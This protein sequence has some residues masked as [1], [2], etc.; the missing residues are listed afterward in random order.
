[1]IR[2][3]TKQRPAITLVEVLMFITLMGMMAGTVLPTLF[4]ATESRQRQDAIALVEQNGAQVMQTIAQEIK[5]AERILYPA[6]GGTG[7]ILA[8]Q[9]ADAN[10]NPTIIALDSGAIVMIQGRARRQLSSE[11]VGVTGFAV[12]NTSSS[13]DR[14]SLAVSLSLRRIIRVLRPVSYTSTFNSVITLY[15]DDVT[16]G[17]PCNCFTPFCSSAETVY[18]S[19]EEDVTGTGFFVWGICDS[20]VCQPASAFVCQLDG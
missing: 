14:Q 18:G 7:Y 20:G 13:D 3:L 15:P 6:T 19:E 1:M 16:E 2:F 4:N 8:L 5:S 17:N 10:E 12:D 11:L 9:M